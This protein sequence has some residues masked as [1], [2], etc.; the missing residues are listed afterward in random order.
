MTLKQLSTIVIA[1]LLV[2]VHC[3]FG[4]ISIHSDYDTIHPVADSGGIVAT[5]EA[6]IPQEELSK[7]LDRAETRSVRQSRRDLP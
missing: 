1:C 5:Q 3:S 6:H 7:Y 2:R 4:A